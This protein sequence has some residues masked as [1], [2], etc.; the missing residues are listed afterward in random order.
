MLL[1][2]KISIWYF[3]NEIKTQVL[4]ICVFAISIGMLD[5]HPTFQKVSIPPGIPALVGTAVSLLLAFR[6]AQSYERWWEARTVWGAIVNDSRTLI[7]QV[8]QFLPNSHKD[9][10]QE[11]AERQIIWTYALGEALRK[12]PFSPRVQAYI[13]VHQ[14]KTFN[15]P[16]ELLDRHSEAVKELSAENIISDF[17]QVQLNET[18]SRLCDSM[19]KCER[20]K[21]TVFPRSYSMLVHTLIYVF[22]AILPF[23]LEDSQLVVEIV[24]TI[25]LPVLFIA[26]EKTAIIM[27]D[28]FENTPVDTPMTALAQTIEINLKQMYGANEI[29]VKECNEL[30]YEM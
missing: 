22:A 21:N 13:N 20:I 12:Q 24:M 18:I 5:L 25:T 4:L 23:G 14:F 1:N 3:I 30:Y 9:A 17:K 8:I 16:N 7:R 28:P 11:F 26:I 10:I 29:P 19:G 2:R 6:T 15:I 27:Q